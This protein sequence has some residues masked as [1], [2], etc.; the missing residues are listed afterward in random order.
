MERPTS[1][2]EHQSRARRNGNT[3]STTNDE[4]SG[5]FITTTSQVDQMAQDKKRNSI[6]KLAGDIEFHKNISQLNET[7]MI[8]KLEKNA[9][10]EQRKLEQ[11]QL[12]KSKPAFHRKKPRARRGSVNRTRRGSVK[13][14][15]VG[16]TKKGVERWNHQFD[17]DEPPPNIIRALRA[18]GHINLKELSEVGGDDLLG[19]P[20]GNDPGDTRSFMLLL[21]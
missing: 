8:R 6:L 20:T 18:T 13:E 11:T 5:T 16:I 15:Y 14:G 7:E 9:H 1:P 19:Y 10:I 3:S 4:P 17:R 21:S 2:A 12:G